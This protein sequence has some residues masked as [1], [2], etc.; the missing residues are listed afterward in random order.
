MRPSRVSATTIASLLSASGASSGFFALGRFT[1]TPVCSRGVVIM[2]MISSTSIM[3]AIGVTLMSALT[4]LRPNPRLA[5]DLTSLLQEIVDEL[6]RRIVHFDGERFDS[7]GERVERHHRGHSHEETERRGN[8]RLRNSSGNGRDTGGLFR[9][10]AL[11]RVDDADGGSEESDEWRHGSDRSQTAQAS[12]Q[13]FNADRRRAFESP[14][15]RLDGLARNFF[16]LGVRLELM[17]AGDKNLSQVTL[18]VLFSES[19]RLVDLSFLEAFGYGRCKDPGLLARGAIGDP[20]LDH[21][22]YRVS[23]HDAEDDHN[24]FRNRSHGRPQLD[25][26]DSHLVSSLR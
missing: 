13:V 5:T 3:S 23:G 17:Q 14:L 25:Y 1:V 8:Q 16:A 26:V 4:L 22:A 9:F 21:D 11:E 12:F 10:H 18:V 2:K 6:R 19:Y 7:V 15:G 24:P 20:A